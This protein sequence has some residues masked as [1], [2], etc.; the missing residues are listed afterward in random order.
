MVADDITWSHVAALALQQPSKM[1]T[2][3]ILS[4]FL[5]AMQLVYWKYITK[6]LATGG[7]CVLDADVMLSKD[8][9]VLVSAS[10]EPLMLICLR[11]FC[12]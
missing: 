4:Q 11:P 9:I 5:A 12:S 7:S 10:K 2:H 8:R 6:L 3:C 1:T